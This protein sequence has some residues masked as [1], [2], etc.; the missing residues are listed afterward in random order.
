MSGPRI[1]VAGATGLV[2]RRLLRIME[3]RGIPAQAIGVYASEASAGD[4]ISYA[5]QQLRIDALSNCNFS[6]FA[7]ALFCIGDEL[8]AQYVPQAQDAG[9]AVVDKSNAFRMDPDVPLVVA[10]VNDS[11]VLKQHRLV[12]NPNC[13]TIVMLHA[14]APLARDFGLKSLW[15]ATYQS[16]SGAGTAAVEQLRQDVGASG[17]ESAENIRLVGKP[18]SLAFNTHCQVGSLKPGGRCSEEQKLALE[19]RKILG[20]GD[21]PVVVHTVRVPVLLGHG[22]AVTARFD[23]AVEA[24][25]I[26]AAWDAAADVLFMGDDI[27]TPVGSSR[28]ERVETGRLRREPDVDNGWS[29]FVTGDNINIGA[30]LN[31]WRLLELLQAAGAVPQLATATGGK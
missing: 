4:A 24:E 19:T 31:G 11:A 6:E 26:I 20:L 16:A 17:Y 2:G 15:A 22:I 8:S 28:H 14:L 10:G 25:Q 13:T 5:C 29:F 12:A 30:A 7:A 18:E 27:P 3:A 23:S 1:A 9:C 21:L